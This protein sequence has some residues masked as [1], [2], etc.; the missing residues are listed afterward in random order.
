MRGLYVQELFALLRT[1]GVEQHRVVTTLGANKTQVSLWANGKRPLPGKLVTAFGEFVVDAIVAAR[2]ALLA[3]HASPPPPSTL[4]SPPTPAEQ[5]D[6]MALA[7]I[8]RWDLECYATSGQ[9]AASHEAYRQRARGYAHHPLTKLTAEDLPAY[10]DALRGQYRTARL[11]AHLLERSDLTE[12][13]HLSPPLRT[14]TTPETYVRDVIT[15]YTRKGADT[16]RE[17]EDC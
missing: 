3:P 15:R 9:L 14:Q 7:Q 4:L 8:H 17:D 11:Y 13:R 5:F 6:D 16:D 12:G 1:L 10:V 2:A